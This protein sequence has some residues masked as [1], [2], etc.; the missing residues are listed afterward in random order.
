MKNKLNRLINRIDDNLLEYSYYEQIRII[1]EKIIH[2]TKNRMNKSIRIL[3]TSSVLS[4]T[5]LEQI[6][7]DI[8]KS[9]DEICSDTNGE[10]VLDN[11]VLYSSTSVIKSARTINTAGQSDYCIFIEK[12]GQ[13]KYSDIEYQINTMKELEINIIGFIY[14]YEE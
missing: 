5:E 9:F 8:K 12:Q 14:V 11:I 10:N 4:Q 3:I 6:T 2:F 13:S 7:D 1:R